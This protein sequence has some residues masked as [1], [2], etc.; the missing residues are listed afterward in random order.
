MPSELIERMDGAVERF[1]L[2]IAADE[3]AGSDDCA[4]P[5]IDAGEATRNHLDLAHAFAGPLQIEMLL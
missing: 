3:Q 5:G 4:H 2:H 1:E